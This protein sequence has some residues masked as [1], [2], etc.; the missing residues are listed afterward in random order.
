LHSKKI[1]PFTAG[2]K[3]S[4]SL[5]KWYYGYKKISKIKGTWKEN[6]YW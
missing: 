2:D 5:I 6:I 4:K 3:I 1:D